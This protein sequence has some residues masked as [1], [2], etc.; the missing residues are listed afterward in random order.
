M[1]LT[2][3]IDDTLLGVVVHAGSS[4]V[5]VTAVQIAWEALVC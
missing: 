2:I 3:L 4:H 5:M 1:Y